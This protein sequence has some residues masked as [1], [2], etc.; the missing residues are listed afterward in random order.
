MSSIKSDG[1]ARHFLPE[2]ETNMNL[3]TWMKTTPA[4]ALS[5]S[6]A[7]QVE[8]QEPRVVGAPYRSETANLRMYDRRILKLL[9]VFVMAACAVIQDQSPP[10]QRIGPGHKSSE[11]STRD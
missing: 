4:D 8:V 5:S 2:K 6:A 3:T 7:T 10:R 11:K 9:A 1:I